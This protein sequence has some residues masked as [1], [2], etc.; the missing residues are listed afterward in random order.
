MRKFSSIQ[1]GEV[2]DFFFL[3]KT[4]TKPNETHLP[5]SCTRVASIAANSRSNESLRILDSQ[6]WWVEP[7]RGRMALREKHAGFTHSR[8]V[9]IAAGARCPLRY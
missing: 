6:A 2:A 7:A 4:N 1:S 8:T 9:T 5:P 3:T